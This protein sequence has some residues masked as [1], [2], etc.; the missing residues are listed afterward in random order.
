MDVRTF[1]HD[2]DPKHTVRI[3]TKYLHDSKIKIFAYPTESRDWNLIEN[4]SAYLKKKVEKETL[5]IWKN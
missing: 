5:K 4:I 3:L 1:Q 2:L